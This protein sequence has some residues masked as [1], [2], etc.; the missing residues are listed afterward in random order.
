MNLPK[1]TNLSAAGVM[2]DLETADDQQVISYAAEEVN[3]EER[4]IRITV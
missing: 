1:S 4:D 2:D 3:D